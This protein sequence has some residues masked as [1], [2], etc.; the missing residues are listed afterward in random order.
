[1][2]RPP[3]VQLD[4]PP[5]TSDGMS[6]ETLTSGESGEAL[7]RSIAGISGFSPVGLLGE[8]L[9]RALLVEFRR[10][11]QQRGASA[12]ARW[13]SVASGFGLEMLPHPHRPKPPQ[14]VSRGLL[15]RD[16]VISRRRNRRC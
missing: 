15:G 10:D 7:T 14:T 8:V 4:V 12:K 1:M 13:F 2:I 3:Q 5:L 16:R 11:L 9:L 6:G